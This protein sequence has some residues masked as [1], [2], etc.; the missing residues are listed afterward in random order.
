M[1]NGDLL[2]LRQGQGFMSSPHAWSSLLGLSLYLP[3][4]DN[5]PG[6]AEREHRPPRLNWSHVLQGLA[7]LLSLPRTL[8]CW[9]RDRMGRARGRAM[10][11]DDLFTPFRPSGFPLGDTWHPGDKVVSLLWHH[12]VRGPYYQE[13]RH[14]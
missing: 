9:A 14:S 5:H 8:R 2:G 6:S 4:Q 7:L 11:R 12:G 10:W 1:K 13:R 3:P